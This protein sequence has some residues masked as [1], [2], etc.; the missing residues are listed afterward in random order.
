MD[1]EQWLQG[2]HIRA[3]AHKLREEA[4]QLDKQAV[5]LDKKTGVGLVDVMESSEMFQHHVYMFT[6]I[7]FDVRIE[8]IYTVDEEMDELLRRFDAN[9]RL[10]SDHDVNASINI[11]DQVIVMNYKAGKVTFTVQHG[12]MEN[13]TYA[14]E[15][16]A[17]AEFLKR[18]K[19]KICLNK[20]DASI[21]NSKLHLKEERD[22]KVFIKQFIPK[23]MIVE[24]E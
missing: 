23:D 1:G 11:G 12:D 24:L 22:H 6:D 8:S 15:L 3:K 18:T 4:R 2:G 17:L 13:N 7:Y 20:V 9:W 10:P 21:A 14:E 19:I 16:E 5:E